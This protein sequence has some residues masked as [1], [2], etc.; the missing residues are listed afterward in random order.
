MFYYYSCIYHATVRCTHCCDSRYGAYPVRDAHFSTCFN[1]CPNTNHLIDLTTCTPQRDNS[2]FGSS[3]NSH[4]SWWKGSETYSIS[5][6][7]SH[8]T[9]QSD[10]YLIRPVSQ[11]HF[12][13]SQHALLYYVHLPFLS[14]GGMDFGFPFSIETVLD[15]LSMAIVAVHP[16]LHSKYA[17]SR[18]RTLSSRTC[19]EYL[20]DLA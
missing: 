18:A 12:C 17:S 8:F 14:K 11:P 10:P 19:P 15:N 5:Q 7:Q 1:T 3:Y 16:A 20:S 13:H 6:S 2:C 9:W 4:C